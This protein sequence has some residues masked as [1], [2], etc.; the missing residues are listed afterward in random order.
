M[1][2]AN[3]SD[4]SGVTPKE[5]AQGVIAQ[6]E[7]LMPDMRAPPVVSV[8]ALNGKRLRLLAR[9]FGLMRV[10]RNVVDGRALLAFSSCSRKFA[11]VFFALQRACLRVLDM[12]SC[13]EITEVSRLLSLPPR[14]EGLTHR[15]QA[16]FTLP[17][18]LALLPSVTDVS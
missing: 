4:L 14:L 5:Y 10:L 3:K 2:A 12:Q 1:V 16:D 11:A 9:L 18:G 13:F 8:C 7:E 15:T 6:V 17:L